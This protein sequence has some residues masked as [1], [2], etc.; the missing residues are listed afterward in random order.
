MEPI[1]QPNAWAERQSDHPVSPLSDNPPPKL[2]SV[3]TFSEDLAAIF[4]DDTRR[5]RTVWRFLI[6]GTACVAATIASIVLTIVYVV[7]VMLPREAPLLAEQEIPAEERFVQMFEQPSAELFAV[8]TTVSLPPFLLVVL[9]CRVLLDRRSIASMG[10]VGSWRSLTVS[11]AAGFV[12]G[13]LPILIIAGVVWGGGWFLIDVAVPPSP[14]LVWLS[15]SLVLAAF[16]EEIIFRAYLLQNLVDVRRITFGVLFTSVVFWIVHGLNPHVFNSPWPAAN[17]FGAGVAL[18]LAYLVS[19]N[20]WFPTAM[21]FGWNFAQ[22][23]LLGIP[24]SG[25]QFEGIVLVTPAEDASDWLTGGE[26]GLEGSALTTAGLAV[27]IG[28][29]LAMLW[30]RKR[31]AAESVIVAELVKAG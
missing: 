21:H 30:R 23:P 6:F 9:A 18:A 16:M 1:D 15:A 31:T 29:F 22:G 26:F 20:I 10:F 2:D 8:S 12:V 14:P 19:G 24:V 11:P 5:L 28:I 7:V 27:L 4:L 13:V 3:R 17:L 25:I